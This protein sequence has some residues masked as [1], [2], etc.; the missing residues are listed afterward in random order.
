MQFKTPSGNFIHST[1]KLDNHLYSIKNS[2]DF[3]NLINSPK[4][5]KLCPQDKRFIFTI[6]KFF[7]STKL[8][9]KQNN[10]YHVKGKNEP[11]DVFFK[12]SNRR[13]DMER[14]QDQAN[15]VQIPSYSQYVP[16]YHEDYVYS[17]A[18]WHPSLASL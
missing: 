2:E 7:I 16:A 18:N 6:A 12:K 9:F 15:F 3:C 10:K 4:V 11:L 1:G 14:K 8:I 13:L 5:N 17:D